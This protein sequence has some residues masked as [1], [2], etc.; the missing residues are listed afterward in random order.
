MVD[1]QAEPRAKLRATNQCTCRTEDFCIIST[2]G[3]ITAASLIIFGSQ[4]PVAEGDNKQ[5]PPNSSNAVRCSGGSF[6]LPSSH[7]RQKL[8]ATAS[9]SR[10]TIVYSQG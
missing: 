8:V 9:L 2:T 5:M 1:T 4:Q 7:C 3:S 10:I 6:M